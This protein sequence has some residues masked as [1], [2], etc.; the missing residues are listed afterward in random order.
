MKNFAAY[1]LNRLNTGH[2]DVYRPASVDA[3]VPIEET[4]GAIAELV[5]AGHVR[6]IG[7]S[8]VGA[9]TIR[10][11]ECPSNSAAF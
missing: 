1:T 2:I 9:E 3:A 4:I 6:H 5:E 8:E 7:L 10:R 11:A